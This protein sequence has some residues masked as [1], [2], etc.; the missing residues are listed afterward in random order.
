MQRNHKQPQEG[1]Y[2]APRNYVWGPRGDLYHRAIPWPQCLTGI[3]LCPVAVRARL[4]LP[5]WGFG[6]KPPDNRRP[7]KWC[8]K[9]R[10]KPCHAHSRT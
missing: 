5:G 4:C 9:L 7:C 6:P 2:L 8:E 10:R 1:W 3:P